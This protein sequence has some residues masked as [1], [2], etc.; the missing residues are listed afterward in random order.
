MEN[1]LFLDISIKT[2]SLFPL[3]ERDKKKLVSFFFFF[4]FWEEKSGSKMDI[5]KRHR[6]IIII[7]KNTGFIH[8]GRESYCSSW[9]FS[10]YSFGGTNCCTMFHATLILNVWYLFGDTCF[11]LIHT[12]ACNIA[13]FVQFL[14]DAI[15]ICIYGTTFMWISI[16]LFFFFHKI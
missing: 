16:F 3:C 9:R 6:C 1:F 14:F 8:H 2:I 11:K 10:Y 13:T 5:F 12:F 4:S 7:D 15:C